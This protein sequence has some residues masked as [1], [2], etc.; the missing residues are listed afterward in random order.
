MPVHGCTRYLP[1]PALIALA[2]ALMLL[3]PDT[4]GA[5]TVLRR[6]FDPV[7]PGTFYA[8]V[9]AGVESTMTLEFGGDSMPIGEVNTVFVENAE[10]EPGTVVAVAEQVGPTTWQ[11]RFTL[12]RPGIWNGQHSY[13]TVLLDGTVSRGDGSFA[14]QAVPQIPARPIVVTRNDNQWPA[15]QPRE[16]AQLLVRFF[17][18]FNENDQV[19]LARMFGPQAHRDLGSPGFRWYSV[20]EGDP[21]QGGRH[22]V[23]FHSNDALAYFD[24]RHQ[25]S[26]RLDLHALDLAP[27]G[28]IGFVATRQANDLPPGPDGGEWPLIGKGRIDCAAKTIDVWSMGMNMEPSGDT[29][30]ILR[31]RLCPEPPLTAPSDAVVACSRAAM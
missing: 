22:F 28:D 5:K 21:S 10:R 1:W 3:A 7:P 9:W 31:S 18:A 13:E 8:S 6:S 12:P 25:Q 17:D 26:E 20:T 24:E 14:L 29:A 16:V 19:Q 2:V 30:A 4:A 23:A 11:A 15:C 27:T